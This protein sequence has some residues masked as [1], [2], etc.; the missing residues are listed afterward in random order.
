MNPSDQRVSNTPDV[1]WH[2]QQCQATESTRGELSGG[3]D[4]LD[5]H[6]RKTGQSLH[7]VR[8]MKPFWSAGLEC[9]RW[10]EDTFLRKCHDDDDA[11]LFVGQYRRR[12]ERD[13]SEHKY[14][15]ITFVLSFVDNIVPQ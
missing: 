9:Y 8:E 4:I 15:V 3:A 6:P 14:A 11:G 7:V 2:C 1:Q 12:D 10:A 5:E 13:R